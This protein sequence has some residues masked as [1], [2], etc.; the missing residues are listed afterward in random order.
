MSLRSRLIIEREF[1]GTKH[2]G[3]T[4]AEYPGSASAYVIDTLKAVGGE[5]LR[6][7]VGAPSSVSQSNIDRAHEVIRLTAGPE[8]TREA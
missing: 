1:W 3:Y 2:L 6:R 8:I 7:A 4:S 5:V